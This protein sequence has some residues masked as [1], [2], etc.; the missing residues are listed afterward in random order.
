MG[1]RNKAGGPGKQSQSEPPQQASSQPDR[2][3]HPSA[4]TGTP[5]PAPATMKKGI[6][7][8]ALIYVEGFQAPADD[9]N[10][11]SI[12]LLKKHLNE[13]FAAP[14]DGVA[15]TL[16]SV[17]VQNDVETEDSSESGDAG[18]KKSAPSTDKG[19]KKKE[20]KFQF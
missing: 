8:S 7:L 3:T 6:Y 16:K 4:G 1:T 15:M 5:P 13:C 14:H 2:A 20:E 9:F 19:R 12:S 10:S 17:D 11:F 18:E